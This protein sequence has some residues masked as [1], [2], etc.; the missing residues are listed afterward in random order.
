MALYNKMNREDLKRSLQQS[1][2]RRVTLSFYRYHRLDNPQAFRD[3]LFAAWEAR[4]V[5]GRIYVA[6][7]GINGQLSV[8][9]HL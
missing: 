8:H 4:G 3:A 7:E 2:E 1:E 5:L 6:S 9:K